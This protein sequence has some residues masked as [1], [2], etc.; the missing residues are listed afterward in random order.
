V[1]FLFQSS[2]KKA[3]RSLGPLLRSPEMDALLQSPNL[4]PARSLKYQFFLEEV[5]KL[6]VAAYPDKM[7]YLVMQCVA[8]FKS[9]WPWQRCVFMSLFL[10]CNDCQ[11]S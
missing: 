11:Q 10:F 9:H 8:Q 1:F 5:S 4:D 3:L 2:C 7:N 6:I